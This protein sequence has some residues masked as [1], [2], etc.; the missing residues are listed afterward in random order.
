MIALL[1]VVGI[2]VWLSLGILGYIIIQ[3][4]GHENMRDEFGLL[5]SCGGFS[6]VTSII[7][8]IYEH[9][10]DFVTDRF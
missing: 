1:I 4:F 2:I 6:F 7:V 10:R 3:K 5:L 9:I 8:V